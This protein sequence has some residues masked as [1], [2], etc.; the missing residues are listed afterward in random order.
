MNKVKVI[1]SYLFGFVV[2]VSLFLLVFLLIVKYSVFNKSFIYRVIDENN[3]YENV[4]K[5][6]V[7]G[8]D[9]YMISSG[10]DNSVLDNVITLGSVKTD[11]K[12][13][14]DSMYIG[15]VY[16]ANTDKMK[17]T[18]ENNIKD[19]L[20][21]QNL[22]IES[23]HELDLFA[24][25]VVKI[26]NNEV[27]L[28]NML[29]GYIP[30]IVKVNSLLNKCI[31]LCIC[32]FVVSLLFLLLLK[33]I[34]VGS[35]I[36]SSGFILLIVKLFVFERIDINNILIIS[37]NFSKVLNSALKYLSV[38]MLEVSIILIIIGFMFSLIKNKRK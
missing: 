27:S 5:S 3:Y 34:N 31:V 23:T 28:Y 2:S 1:L 9:D 7:D 30:K 33:F 35:C 15:K 37:D 38:Y 21:K 13:Y 14:V 12:K 24:S 36:M 26:Y 22:A 17:E 6:I 18:L 19:Y 25:D 29:N 16:I 11:V 32:V 4:Y 20:S 8:V 10:L